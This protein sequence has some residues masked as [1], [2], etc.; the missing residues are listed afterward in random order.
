MDDT[1]TDQ[2]ANIRAIGAKK[3]SPFLTT[4]EA[5]FY[6]GLKPQT[7]IKM[8]MERRGPKYRKHGRHVFYHID[9]LNE[10]SKGEAR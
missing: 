8:R 10:W 1:R 6:L 2:G 3:G 9:E 4:K 7:L 5:A